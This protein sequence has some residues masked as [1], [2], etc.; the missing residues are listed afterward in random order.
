MNTIYAQL[1]LRFGLIRAITPRYS[2][3]SYAIGNS[4]HIAMDNSPSAAAIKASSRHAKKWVS[5]DVNLA[6]QSQRL[7]RMEVIRKLQDWDDLGVIELKTSGVISVYRVSKKLPSTSTEVEQLVDALYK[8]L[9]DREAQELTRM[10]E[11][12]D[13]VT[14]N[15]CF[16]RSLAQHFGDDL[17]QQKTECGHC[18]WCETHQRLQLKTAP[19]VPWDRERFGKVLKAVEARDD[20][21]FLARVAFGITSPRVTQMKLSNDPVFGSMAD[22]D[23]VV[24]VKH[25]LWLDVRS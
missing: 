7:D 20:A 5:I 19:P 25:Q 13:L 9:Q 15:S 1:E 6:A 18:T 4:S 17:P 10:Q 16:A 22:H 14:G 2:G 12:I 21:R 8:E 24:S 3:Y 11:V 23:F